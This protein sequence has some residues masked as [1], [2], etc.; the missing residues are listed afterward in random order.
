MQG[1]QDIYDFVVGVAAEMGI[2]HSM[3][4]GEKDGVYDLVVWVLGELSPVPLVGTSE[5]RRLQVREKERDVGIIS[6]L[7]QDSLAVLVDVRQK[8]GCPDKF[9]ESRIRVLQERFGRED[10]VGVIE[11]PI[12][13][14]Q[15]EVDDF[16]ARVFPEGE[17]IDLVAVMRDQVLHGNVVGI[18]RKHE[19][20]DLFRMLLDQ[21]G[22][23]G[24]VR[25]SR[26][27]GPAEIKQERLLFEVFVEIGEGIVFCILVVQG[28]KEHGTR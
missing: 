21:V 28:R 17:P 23:G 26:K 16:I 1:K 5:R 20:V 19:K 12:L 18:S 8:D 22:H 15:E 13:R 25:I 9:H 4:V 11:C 24:V 6:A 3:H 10:G 27:H 14:L 7:V 2:R